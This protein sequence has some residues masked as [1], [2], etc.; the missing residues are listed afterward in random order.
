MLLL[1]LQLKWYHRHHIAY[2]EHCAR[3]QQIIRQRRLSSSLQLGICKWPECSSSW[4]YR[5]GS[6]AC[7]RFGSRNLR[8]PTYCNRQPGRNKRQ[9]VTV[10]VLNSATRPKSLRW[11]LSSPAHWRTT[12]KVEGAR[13]Q[14]TLQITVVLHVGFIT[15]ALHRSTNIHGDIYLRGFAKGIYYMNLRI[16]SNKPIVRKLQKQ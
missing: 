7:K 16:G 2:T 3:W 8:I 5:S 11:L 13:G 9:N 4:Q 10:L 15:N 14:A 12:L 1:L 6:S